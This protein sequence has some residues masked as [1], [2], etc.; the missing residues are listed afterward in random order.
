MTLIS[1]RIE[2]AYAYDTPVPAENAPNHHDITPQTDSDTIPAYEY[3]PFGD[4]IASSGALADET[5]FRFSTKHHDGACPGPNGVGEMGLVY[6]GLRYY[7]PDQGRWVNRDP[8]GE[9][10]GNDLY[11]F[12][13]N[14]PV[15]ATPPG[16]PFARGHAE[17]SRFQGEARQFLRSSKGN[18]MPIYGL[19]QRIRDTPVIVRSPRERQTVLHALPASISDGSRSWKS[20]VFRKH[21]TFSPIDCLSPVPHGQRCV[22]P[23]SFQSS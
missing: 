7:N 10:G 12:V 19:V 20:A 4:T 5:P 21:S 15:C 1:E 14:D 13:E 17:W 18:G 3:D 2:T 6:Y 16:P 23:D 8:I 22:E 11:R 9:K